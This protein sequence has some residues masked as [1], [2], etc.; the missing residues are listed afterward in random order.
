MA[1]GNNFLTTLGLTAAL[2]AGGCSPMTVDRETQLARALVPEPAPEPPPAK[3][4]PLDTEL[5][6]RARAIVREAAASDH[7]LLRANAVETLQHLPR[8]EAKAAIGSA[9]DDPDPHV[10]F[11]AAMAAGRLR[12]TDFHDE[13]RVLADGPSP[14]GRVAAIFALHRIGDTSLSHRLE[15]YAF[16]ADPLVRAN[17]AVALGLLEEPSAKVLLEPMMMEDIDPNVRLNAAEALWRQR[18]V[19]GYEAVLAASISQYADDRVLG[20][21]ALAAPHDL[22]ALPALEGKL[23]DDYAEVTLAAARGLG[24]LGSDRGYAVAVAHLDDEDP[25]RRSM[26]A[27]ALGSIGR[28]DAQTHLRPL[29]NDSEPSVRLAAANAILRITETVAN[30]PSQAD[31]SLEEQR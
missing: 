19:T 14:N 6:E 11:A 31:A 9:L 26:A 24:E 22:R 7:A 27:L 1:L 23:T 8:E 2:V 29:L 16:D 18:S 21:L 30:R 15:D 5:V 4:V 17:T 25:R 3:D 28:T 13:L 12:L 10:R 20:T